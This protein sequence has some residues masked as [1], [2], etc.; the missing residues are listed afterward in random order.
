[1]K[2]CSKCK[3]QKSYLDFPKDKY[4]KDGLTSSCKK[5]RYAQSNLWGRKNYLKNKK[6]KLI[7]NLN[8]RK[9]N[10]NKIYAKRCEPSNKIANMIR[11]RTCNAITKQLT[12]KK[13]STL[14]FLGCSILELME[15]LESK[16]YNK[17]SWDN[18]GSYW[19]ID[20]IRPCASFD[21]TKI[22][23]QKQCFHFSNLQPLT[24]K[25]NLSKGSKY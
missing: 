13:S 6:T 9:N 3:E 21:L 18:Y 5:C 2:I 20:H 25:E 7:K 14:N 19:H 17:M 10:W 23:Q 22:E 24:K 1:M 8:Y 4:T 12:F 15:Y 16:F 11:S